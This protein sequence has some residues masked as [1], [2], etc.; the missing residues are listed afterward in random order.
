[1][2]RSAGHP[3]VAHDVGGAVLGH[4][5]Q[6]GQPTDDA[7]LH[8]QERVPAVRRD[9]PAQGRRGCEVVTAVLGDRVVDGRD[10]REAGALQREQAGAEGLVVVDDVEV[11]LPTAQD[12]RDAQ[13]ERQRLRERRR[14]HERELEHVDR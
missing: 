6:R 11:A 3:E 13:A 5:Q 14:A 12:L 4:R 2:I 9:P 8:A 7:R 1:V 10:D